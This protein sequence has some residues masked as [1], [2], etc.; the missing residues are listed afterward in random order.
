M[1]YRSPETSWIILS[2][3]LIVLYLFDFALQIVAICWLETI[4]PLFY[5]VDSFVSQCTSDYHQQRTHFK[6][7]TL[8]GGPKAKYSFLKSFD[9][10][11]NHCHLT[12][13][14]RRLCLRT[15]ATKL[16]CLLAK[17]FSSC[18]IDGDLKP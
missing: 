17:S 7:V 13:V 18:L 8:N 6:H 9:Q 4:I 12:V 3:L 16:F 14:Q 5:F 2:A 11:L 10:F 15:C 1:I